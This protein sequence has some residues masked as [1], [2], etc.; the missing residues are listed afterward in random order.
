[1]RKLDH[2]RASAP[3]PFAFRA[4]I[5]CARDSRRILLPIVGVMNLVLVLRVV[6]ENLLQVIISKCININNAKWPYR[7]SSDLAHF[8]VFT[9]GNNF[10]LPY[11]HPPSL[12][13]VQPN[14]PICK[15]ME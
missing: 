10:A 6:S 8:V 2:V 1:M 15:R 11:S 14:P 4:N 3:L 9:Y 5:C 7:Y 13:Q 12:P